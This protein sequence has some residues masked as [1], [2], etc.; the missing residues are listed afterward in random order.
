MGR[1][2]DLFER[3]SRGGEAAID[4]LIDDRQSEELFLDF[5]RSADNGTGRRLHDTDRQNLAKA[6][7]GFGNS[8]GGVIIWGVDCRDRPA[9][10]D[11]AAARFPIENP[12]RFVSRLE[13][14]VS[15]CTIPPHPDVRH[16]AIAALAPDLGFVVTYVAKSYLAPHQC[17]QP[18]QYHVRAGSNF[19]PASHGVLAG[20]FGRQPQPS[21]FHNWLVE[22]ARI[23]P[24]SQVSSQPTL[25][26]VAVLVLHNRG[27]GLARDV[28]VN[29]HLWPPSGGTRITSHIRREDWTGESLVGAIVSVVC[30]EAFRLTPGGQVTPVEFNFDLAPP[31]IGSL[32][33]KVSYG[34]SGWPMTQIEKTTEAAELQTLFSEVLPTDRSQK[35]PTNLVAS[36]ILPG[37]ENR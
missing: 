12:K 1:A 24:V 3:L 14:A 35:D 21:L 15:G 32:T 2:E 31:F 13:G 10:G 5:K 7:S 6:I 23:T 4:A 33:Y 26:F 29:F 25:Q 9:I 17:L 11:V 16:I 18:P 30:P 28:Y 36:T 27:P 34:C 8:E 20:M 37:C 22:K 19:I